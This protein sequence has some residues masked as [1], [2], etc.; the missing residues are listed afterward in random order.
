MIQ[1]FIDLCGKLRVPVVTEKTEWVMTVIVFLGI[2]INGESL[3]LCIP[4]EKRDKAL[5]LLNNLTGKRKATIKQLQVLTGYLNF[6]TRVVHPRRV[7]TRRMYNK[8]ARVMKNKGRILKPYH[9]INI[10]GEFRFDCEIWR[11]FLNNYRELT[12]CRLMID[13]ATNN[14]SKVLNFYSDASTNPNFGFGAV[15]NQ[16]WIVARWEEDY[17][18]TFEPSIEYLELLALTA[19]LLTWSQQLKDQC[20]TI[21]CDNMSV[22]Q[23]VN[24]SSSSCKQCMYLF[25]LINLDN[26]IR[27]RRVFAR[28]VRSEENSLT[29]S[30]SRLQFK[31]FRRLGP[32]MEQSPCAIS[33]QVWPASRI[34]QN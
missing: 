19:A 27:N 24:N 3:C 22:V 23:M 33:P 4:L 30:L 20:I 32:H 7:F 5:R 29:D 11:V 16:Q 25:R 2:L 34:W 17:V 10:D 15:F 13:M 26:L 6:L 28:H 9:H 21:F 18:K 31:C 8:Y 12:L 1:G 14:T